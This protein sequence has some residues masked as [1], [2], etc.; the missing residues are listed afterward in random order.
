MF[1]FGCERRGATKFSDC[2]KKDFERL[3]QRGGRACLRNPPSQDN[4]ISAPRCGNGI[5]ESGEECDCGTPQR[6]R[7]QMISALVMLILLS[8]CLGTVDT[9]GLIRNLVK[10]SEYFISFS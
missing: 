1:V 8:I 5:L 10:S 2:S 4:I 9:L 7:K 6:Q 3:I